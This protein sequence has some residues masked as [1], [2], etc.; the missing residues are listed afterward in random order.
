MGHAVHDDPALERWNAMRE[1][2]W[3]HFKLTKRNA[4]P[5]LVMGVLIPAGLLW[6][7]ASSDNKFNMVARK[8]NDSLI[9]GASVAAEPTEE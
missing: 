9:R 3:A 2:A 7:A 5:I 4:R 1:G 8:K 6:L